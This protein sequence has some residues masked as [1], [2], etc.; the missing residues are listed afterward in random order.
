M[1]LTMKTMWTMSDTSRPAACGRQR[2]CMRLSKQMWSLCTQ[3]L[4]G[5]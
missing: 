2:R 4:P 5:H 3:A 1:L